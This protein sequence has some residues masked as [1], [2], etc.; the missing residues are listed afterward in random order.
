MEAIVFP[1][2]SF[3][4]FTI[5]SGGRVANARSTETIKSAMNALSLK[6]DVRRMIA[7]MLKAT[8][9]ETATR[10]MV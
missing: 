3:K 8:S 1:K 5:V 4:V 2:P 10:L 6:V 7:R 9:I